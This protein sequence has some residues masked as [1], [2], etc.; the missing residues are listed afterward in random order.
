MAYDMRAVVRS[1]GSTASL[2]GGIL[3]CH[4]EV[5]PMT[6][7]VGGSHAH[8]AHAPRKPSHHT[9]S[10]HYL[11]A[12]PAI[13]TRAI[14]A[15]SGCVGRVVGAS[16]WKSIPH[17]CMLIIQPAH[18]TP[19]PVFQAQGSHPQSSLWSSLPACHCCHRLPDITILST[20]A[21]TPHSTRC[22]VSQAIHVWWW[23]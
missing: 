4:A 7:V 5:F 13:G 3:A 17:Y 19:F 1:T 2:G 23:G 12:W 22:A 15:K 10:C 18:K 14:W 20:P 16:A 9:P 8:I 21:I 11:R 6:P